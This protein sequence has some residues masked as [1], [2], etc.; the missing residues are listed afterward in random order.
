V[1]PVATVVERP[2]SGREERVPLRGLRRR[3]AEN[4]ARSKRTAAHYTYVEEA[5]LT[6]LVTLRDRAGERWEKRGIKLTFLPLVVKAVVA[7]LKKYP[8]VNASLDEEKGEVVLHYHYDIGVA[9]ATEAGLIVPVVRSADEKSIFELAG[10]LQEL[11]ERAKAGK[12]AREELSGST[13][14]ITSL[15]ALGGVMATPIINY[16]EVAIL[17]VHRI[18]PMPVVRGGQ[19]VVRQMANL[20]LSLDHRV[21]DGFEGASFLREVI[22]LLEDPLLMFLEAT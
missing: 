13:F 4:M 5:D 2:A 21:V 16:P 9:T 3:I 14:T 7:A 1:K 20:S 19:I 18:R 22:T 15:G 11:T 12:A 17:G 6:E 10:E 8:M